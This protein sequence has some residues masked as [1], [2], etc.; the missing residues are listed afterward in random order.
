MREYITLSYNREKD[1]FAT[2]E[3]K[4]NENVFLSMG[5]LCLLVI[6]QHVSMKEQEKIDIRTAAMDRLIRELVGDRLLEPS[7]YVTIDSV[8]KRIIIDKMTLTNDSYHLVTH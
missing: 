7:K 4:S 5:E 1:F 8:S 6:P 2:G 3:L